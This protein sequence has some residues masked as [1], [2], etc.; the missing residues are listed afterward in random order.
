[1]N[2]QLNK[3]LICWVFRAKTNQPQVEWCLH[4]DLTDMSFILVIH[5]SYPRF[6]SKATLGDRSFT[7]AAPKLWNALPF[8]IRS[9]N[10]VSS[11]KAKLKT[12][13]FRLAFLS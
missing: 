6:K 9:A 12:H 7:C 11:F 10:T 5:I 13:L 4:Y 1:M 2:F 3:E 8:N